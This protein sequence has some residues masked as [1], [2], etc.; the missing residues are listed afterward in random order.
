[1]KETD[2]TN[3]NRWVAIGFLWLGGLALTL[4]ASAGYRIGLFDRQIESVQ[5]FFDKDFSSKT[6]FVCDQEVVTTGESF[7][8]TACSLGA[9]SEK[10][11]GL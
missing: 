10:V 8:K 3:T 11:K 4:S 6:P 7:L 1:M 2:Y 5:V 9:A